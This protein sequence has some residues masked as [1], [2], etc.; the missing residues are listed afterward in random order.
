M[1]YRTKARRGATNN[2][3]YVNFSLDGLGK[4]PFCGPHNGDN[5]SNRSSWG[6]KVAMKNYYRTGKKRKEYPKYMRKWYDKHYMSEEDKNYYRK[7]DN[8]FYDVNKR[9]ISNALDS[10]CSC[11]KREK[12]NFSSTLFNKFYSN[13]TKSGSIYLSNNILNIEI[14]FSAKKRPFDSINKNC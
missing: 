3:E 8:K 2:R 6:K 5:C 13:Y 11:I 7:Q 9:D 14:N 4:C 10:L 12:N 1:S